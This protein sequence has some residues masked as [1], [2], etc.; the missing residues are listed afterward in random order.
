MYH[1]LDN[2]YFAY[3]VKYSA[4]KNKRIFINYN[5]N[6]YNNPVFEFNALFVNAMKH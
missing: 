1:V 3:V 6:N 5:K 2:N 4:K